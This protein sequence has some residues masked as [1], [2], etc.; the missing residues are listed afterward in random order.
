[1]YYTGHGNNICVSGLYIDDQLVKYLV[2]QH[3]KL[4]YSVHHLV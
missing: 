3:L 4:P 2:I 1:M